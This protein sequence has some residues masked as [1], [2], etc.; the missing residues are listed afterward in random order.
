MLI[1]IFLSLSHYVWYVSSESL[2]YLVQEKM[3]I[4]IAQR[5]PSIGQDNRDCVPH[6]L[7]FYT[8]MIKSQKGDRFLPNSFHSSMPNLFHHHTYQILLFM[9][10]T[11][12]HQFKTHSIR[13][14]IVLHS[15]CYLK[16]LSRAHRHYSLYNCGFYVTWSAIILNRYTFYFQKCS[17][18]VNK[19]FSHLGRN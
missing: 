6:L 8:F 19:L 9:P 4:V 15:S 11:K 3:I 7:R 5:L 2:K 18:L 13:L 1:I 16:I 17:H 10:V 12:P 14:S